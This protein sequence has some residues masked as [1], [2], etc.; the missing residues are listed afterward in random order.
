[1]SEYANENVKE[2][3]KKIPVALYDSVADRLRRDNCYS[4][5]QICLEC[6][7]EMADAWEEVNG[8]DLVYVPAHFEKRKGT[9]DEE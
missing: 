9:E 4:I 8:S 1:M 6:I 3:T 7:E 2:V 5:W